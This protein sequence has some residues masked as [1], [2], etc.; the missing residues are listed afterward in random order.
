MG[1]RPWFKRR[2]A[3]GTAFDGEQGLGPTM[4]WSVQSPNEAS[5]F[6]NGSR[7]C[8]GT[9]R[10][11]NTSSSCTRKRVQNE[12]DTGWC[13]PAVECD[14]DGRIVGTMI[15]GGGRFMGFR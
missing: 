12:T 6:K 14:C 5:S 3:K 10:S 4:V 8:M 9:N 1:T 15:D 7:M 13:S 11:G 2:T